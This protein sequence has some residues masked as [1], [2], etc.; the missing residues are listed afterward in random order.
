MLYSAVFL[1]RYIEF[2]VVYLSRVVLSGLYK[3]VIDSGERVGS[4]S[5]L[6]LMEISTF[7]QTL[8]M[9]RLSMLAT[10]I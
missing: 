9:Y 8:R 4:K 1:V 10:S 5:Q 6:F 2:W 3:K 7:Y